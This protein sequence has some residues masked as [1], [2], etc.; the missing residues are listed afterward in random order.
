[1][2]VIH[3]FSVA[4]A[5]IVIYYTF[6]RAT[7]HNLVYVAA[8]T[9]MVRTALEHYRRMAIVWYPVR[10]HAQPDSRQPCVVRYKGCTAVLLVQHAAGRWF[11]SILHT[12]NT[13]VVYV[14]Q[15]I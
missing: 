6:Q 10:K 5:F 15:N 9:A 12:S 1:M 4:N 11:N 3:N 8:H 13:G 7:R 14:S 2:H